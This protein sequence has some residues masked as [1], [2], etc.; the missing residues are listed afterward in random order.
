MFAKMLQRGD[1]V[2]VVVDSDG[3][4]KD[5]DGGGGDAA[6]GD[7]GGGPCWGTSYG[8]QFFTVHEPNQDKLSRCRQ[9]D[10]TLDDHI[11]AAEKLTRL[12]KSSDSHT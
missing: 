2:E 7:S 10:Y 12:M 4:K 1:D 8:K 3:D 9:Q 5:D 6:R 11:N